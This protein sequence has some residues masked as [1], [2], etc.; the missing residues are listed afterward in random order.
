MKRKS[1]LKKVSIGLVIV[2]LFESVLTTLRTYVFSH[3][4]SRIDVELGAR[5]FRHLVSLP[6]A[7]F[8]ARRVG[9]AVARVREL[10]KS[11]AFS[12]ATRSRWCSTWR[13]P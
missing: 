8:Q 3:T 7:Y 1:V 13:S 10:E 6:L 12:R 2:V 5:L 4:T 9:D 11:A